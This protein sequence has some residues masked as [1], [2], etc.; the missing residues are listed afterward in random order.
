M[1]T[2]SKVYKGYRSTGL[3]DQ[4]NLHSNLGLCHSVTLSKITLFVGASPSSFV[5]LLS[6]AYLV[7][8]EDAYIVYL[9]E[10]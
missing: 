2:I 3:W 5:K 4:T 8:V 6:C 9:A 7:K 10:C 1:I